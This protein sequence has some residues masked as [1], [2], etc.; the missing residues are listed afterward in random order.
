LGS[1]FGRLHVAL[2]I[3]WL[4]AKGYSSECR[5]GSPGHEPDRWFDLVWRGNVLRRMRCSRAC[6]G[7]IGAAWLETGPILGARVRPRRV[8][9]LGLEAR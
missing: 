7:R 9:L 4:R 1:L 6:G 3:L 5:P 2:S 8:P